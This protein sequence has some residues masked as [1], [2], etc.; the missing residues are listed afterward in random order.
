[1]MLLLYLLW[2]FVIYKKVHFKW[3]DISI[4]NLTVTPEAAHHKN[5]KNNSLQKRHRHFAVCLRRRGDR[6]VLLRLPDVQR[7]SPAQRRSAAVSWRGR[8][9]RNRPGSSWSRLGSGPLC[10]PPSR[11][12]VCRACG[13]ARPSRTL[14]PAAWPCGSCRTKRGCCRFISA[15]TLSK[16]NQPASWGHVSDPRN[17]REIPPMGEWDGLKI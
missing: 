13:A 14:W 11:S 8:A 1:M 7:L 17:Q 5:H 12:S 10:A 6:K 4:K 3:L 15:R 2:C 9:G 16:T